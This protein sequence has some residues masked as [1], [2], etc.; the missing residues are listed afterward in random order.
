VPNPVDFTAQP[1]AAGSG[2]FAK[3]VMPAAAGMRCCSL[4]HGRKTVDSAPCLASN[5]KNSNPG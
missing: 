1:S 4:H 5:G 3:T 2:A